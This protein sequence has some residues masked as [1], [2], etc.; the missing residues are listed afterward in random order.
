MEY[1]VVE[2][3]KRRPLGE[4]PEDPEGPWTELPADWRTSHTKQMYPQPGRSL[5]W[6]E[7]TRHVE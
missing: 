2:S 7:G 5:L 4:A 6:A 3:R 1:S